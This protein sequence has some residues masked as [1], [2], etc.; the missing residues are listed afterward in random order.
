MKHY[1]NTDGDSGILAYE[2]G[3]DWIDIR[4]A[5][6][7]YRYTAQK[8]GLTNVREMKRLAATGHD[9]NTFINQ[10]ARVRDGAERID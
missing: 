9:L 1:L 5:D 8:V 3:R 2:C 7:I 10:H 6:G 4:W